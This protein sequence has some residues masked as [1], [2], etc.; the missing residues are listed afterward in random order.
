MAEFV[1]TRTAWR[2]TDDDGRFYAFNALTGYTAQVAVLGGAAR[3]A[4]DVPAP[5]GFRPRVAKVWLAADHTKRKR[6]VCYTPSATAFTT[7]GTTVSVDYLG[8]ATDFV[9]YGS[10]GERHKFEGRN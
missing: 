6:V 9:T 2:Y 7:I 3:V 5:A 8:T 10:A 1:R 4:G